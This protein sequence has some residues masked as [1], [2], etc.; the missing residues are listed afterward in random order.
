MNCER[1]REDLVNS[2][3]AGESPL[4]GE[5]ALHVRSCD[6]CRSLFENETKLLFSIDVGLRIMV[7]QEMPPSLLPDLRARLSEQSTV[8]RAWIP[9]WGLA[10]AVAAVVV[11]FF[12]LNHLRPKQATQP[13][14]SANSISAPARVS[15]PAPTEQLVPESNVT[16]SPVTHHRANPA[17]LAPVSIEASSEVIVLTVEREAFARFVAEIPQRQEVAVAL[18]K[19]ALAQPD[20]PVEIALVRIDQMELKPLEQTPDN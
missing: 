17:I 12:G 8:R 5:L 18:T 15:D 20:L 9:A 16:W 1:I 4:S 2:L 7:N 3:A 13:N 14:L 6:S 19:P 11:L 10:A